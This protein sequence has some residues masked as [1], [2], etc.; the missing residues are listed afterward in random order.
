[1][2]AIQLSYGGVKAAINGYW[3]SWLMANIVNI[4]AAKARNVSLA[5]AAWRRKPGENI[6]N[7]LAQW[8][9]LAG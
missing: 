7:P 9:W 3:L 1:M 2:A 8:L 5:M 4:T 6:S